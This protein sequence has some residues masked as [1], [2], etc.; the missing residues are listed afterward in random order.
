M[1]FT[2]CVL[3]LLLAAAAL[4]TRS[5]LYYTTLFLLAHDASV[6]RFCL[7]M[8]VLLAAT[9]TWSYMLQAWCTDLLGS[10]LRRLHFLI[11]QLTL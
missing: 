2:L 9:A 8:S 11:A 1:Q 6:L 5:D 3:M 4:F 7:R 10:F